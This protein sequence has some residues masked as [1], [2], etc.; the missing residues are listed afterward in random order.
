MGWNRKWSVTPTQGSFAVSVPQGMG[1]CRTQTAEEPGLPGR[2][3]GKG[4][5]GLARALLCSLVQRGRLEGEGN[6]A[7]VWISER[8]HLQV[9]RLV[10]PG[11]EL[12]LWPQRPSEGLSPTQ[13]R[14]EEAASSAAVTEVES[15]VRPEVASPREEAA[16]PG[17]GMCQI[18]AGFPRYHLNNLCW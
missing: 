10:L 16:E 2:A 12:R 7:P 5:P 4:A 15:A 13:P 17:P 8:L 6:V 14:L 18:D 9:S 1:S 11:F 3:A